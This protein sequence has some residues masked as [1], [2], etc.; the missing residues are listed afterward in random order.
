[1]SDLKTCPTCGAT[2]PADAAGGAC[3]KCLLEAGF[4]GRALPPTSGRSSVQSRSQRLPTPASTRGVKLTSR[5]GNF[6]YRSVKRIRPPAAMASE[7]VT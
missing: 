5:T 1:M 3:P 2:L 6:G 4:E 7:L